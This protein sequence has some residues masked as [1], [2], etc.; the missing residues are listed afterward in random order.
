MNIKKYSTYTG[1]YLSNG[2]I[3]HID[4][5]YYEEPIAIYLQE[6]N[7]YI[8]TKETEN[9]STESKKLEICVVDANSFTTFIQD[10]FIYLDKYTVNSSY[11]SN[12]SSGNNIQMNLN[13]ITNTYLFFVK[14]EKTKQQ[15]REEKINE[16]INEN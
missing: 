15:F 16:L 13:T 14:V 10:D 7:L 8:F 4:I 1:N 11:L 6:P 5:G 2:S 12:T 9:Y 3:Y